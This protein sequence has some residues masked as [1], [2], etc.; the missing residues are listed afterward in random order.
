MVSQTQSIAIVELQKEA[1]RLKE[2]FESYLEDLELFSKPEFWE[3]VQ[4][5][6]KANKQLDIQDY[7]K[8]MGI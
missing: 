7:A 4:E 2:E 8:K 5:A 3:A 6:E 1:K